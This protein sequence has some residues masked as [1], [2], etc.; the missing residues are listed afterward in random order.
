MTIKKFKILIKERYDIGKSSIHRMLQKLCFN[1]ITGRKRHYK[2]DQSS[3][4][5]FKKKSTRGT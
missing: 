3:Q 2:S 4:E 1:H 5:E